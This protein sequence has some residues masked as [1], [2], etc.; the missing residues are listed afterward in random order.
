MP[1]QRMVNN[2]LDEG[3]VNLADCFFA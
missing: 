2:F 3:Y 1:L